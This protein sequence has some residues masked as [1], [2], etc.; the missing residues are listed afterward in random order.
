MPDM[1]NHNNLPRM[2]KS[3]ER[4][5]SLDCEATTEGLKQLSVHDITAKYQRLSPLTT[6]WEDDEESKCRDGVF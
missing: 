1:P 2:R 3:V 6:T 4:K 5:P